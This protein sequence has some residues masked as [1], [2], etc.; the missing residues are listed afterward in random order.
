[1]NSI[2]RSVHHS[3][4]AH[5]VLFPYLLIMFLSESGTCHILFSQTGQVV[6]QVLSTLFWATCFSKT[7]SQ[8]TGKWALSKI[9][10]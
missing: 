7:Y 1:M 4:D 9:V 8:E 3:E 6:F 10:Q 2:D 5:D